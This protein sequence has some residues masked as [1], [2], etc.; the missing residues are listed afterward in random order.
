MISTKSKGS[1]ANMSMT[2]SSDII[3][4]SSLMTGEVTRLFEGRNEEML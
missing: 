2:R 1:R 4:K 3:K